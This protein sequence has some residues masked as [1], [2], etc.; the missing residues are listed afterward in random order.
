M[1]AKK[2]GR[3]LRAVPS[4]A[5]SPRNSLRSSR[6]FSEA[7]KRSEF[8]ATENSSLGINRVARAFAN[9]QCASFAVF[10]PDSDQLTELLEIESWDPVDLL[11]L[12]FHGLIKLAVKARPSAVAREKKPTRIK[13]LLGLMDYTPGTL[14]NYQH[15]DDNTSI[16][17]AKAN[18]GI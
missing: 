10:L 9:S 6:I 3:R 8:D 5:P 7:E 2:P 17:Q 1:E 12:P 4:H 13:S 16:S 15:H 11:I 18:F 14:G